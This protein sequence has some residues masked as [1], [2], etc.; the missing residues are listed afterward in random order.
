M[1]CLSAT[2]LYGIANVAEEFIV[3]QNDR[4]EYLA[5]IGI[6]GSIVSGVQLY[7]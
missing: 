3:K 7:V 1:L 5:M 6:F 4:S 2:V